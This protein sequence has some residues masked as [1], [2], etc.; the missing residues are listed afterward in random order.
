MTGQP[1]H[2]QNGGLTVL[3]N[4][5]NTALSTVIGKRRLAHDPLSFEINLFKSNY[6]A[7]LEPPD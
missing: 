2:N 5:G 3:Q 1:S 7:Q 4:C 6:C